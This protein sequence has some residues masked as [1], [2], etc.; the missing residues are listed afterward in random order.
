MVEVRKEIISRLNLYS[1]DTPTCK[2]EEKSRRWEYYSG[3]RIKSHVIQNIYSPRRNFKSNVSYGMRPSI[4]GTQIVK[5]ERYG[6]YG[7]LF[8]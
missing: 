8:R 1:V 4:E 3:V 5:E 7:S 2:S 6:G